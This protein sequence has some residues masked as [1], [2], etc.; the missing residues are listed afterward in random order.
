MSVWDLVWSNLFT[1][2]ASVYFFALP[3]SSQLAL[4]Q[5]AMKLGWST[6][7]LLVQIGQWLTKR[8]P[9]PPVVMIMTEMDM[10]EEVCVI[11]SL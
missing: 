10:E 11:T 2:T 7:T 9:E 4:L 6:T 1:S 5:A 3:M 8:T